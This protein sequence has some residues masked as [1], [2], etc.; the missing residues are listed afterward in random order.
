MLHEG[1]L[2][3]L[4]PIGRDEPDLGL[5]LAVLL[6]FLFIFACRFTFTLGDKGQPAPVGRPHRTMSVSRASG[7]AFRFATCTGC[8][9]NRGTILVLAV[10]DGGDDEGHALPIRRDT[11]PTQELE[12]V[13][14]FNGDCS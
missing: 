5:A 3:R 7:E 11:R 9:P 6:L 1:E 8:Y 10:V 13:Q 4:A 12:L 2:A 14:V